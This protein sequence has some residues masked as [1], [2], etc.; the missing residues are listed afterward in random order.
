MD[1]A[2]IEYVDLVA[3]ADVVVTKPGYG[4]VSDAIAAR[5]RMLYTDRGDFPEYPIMVREMGEW[6]PAE[7][8]AN[9]ELLGGR[10]RGRDRTAAREADARSAARRDRGRRGGRGADPGRGRLGYF[11]WPPTPGA[12]VLYQ[13]SFT[14]PAFSI[15]VA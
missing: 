2:R 6:L 8:V 13:S 1:A 5:T 12:I 10:L 11:F 7:Y 14:A 15:L 4:I 3:A 9:D